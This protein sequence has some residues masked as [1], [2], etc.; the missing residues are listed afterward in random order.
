MSAYKDFDAMFPELASDA[1]DES[2]G[3]GCIKVFGKKYYFSLNP[4]AA[5]ILS[6]VRHSSE[7]NMPW[8]SM[9]R[10]AYAIFGEDAL[11][12]L[13]MHPK[14]STKV[15]GEMISFAIRAV[16]GLEESEPAEMTED[17]FGAP[18]SKKK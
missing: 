6:M 14:F 16:Q 13:S 18:Q 17:D 12:E 1:P 15:L 7:K 4:P 8:Q 3:K 2:A 5:L 9:V 10:L 11:N